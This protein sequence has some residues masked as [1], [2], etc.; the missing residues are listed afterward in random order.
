MPFGLNI[1]PKQFCALH[2]LGTSAFNYSIDLLYDEFYSSPAQRRQKHTSHLQIHGSKCHVIGSVLSFMAQITNRAC[3]VFSTLPLSKFMC[4][5]RS[6]YILSLSLATMTRFVQIN[7]F[8][9]ISKKLCMTSRE[10]LFC[11]HIQQ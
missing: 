3:L 7:I 1:A 2:E 4:Y 6:L 11:H 9:A 10:Y 5:H 8:N